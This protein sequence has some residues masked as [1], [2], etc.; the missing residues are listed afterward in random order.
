V[1]ERRWAGQL[2]T[3]NCTPSG[4]AAPFSLNAVH[5]PRVASQAIPTRERF[6]TPPVEAS[7]GVMKNTADAFAACG[8]ESTLAPPLAAEPLTVWIDAV[9]CRGTTMLYPVIGTALVV[10]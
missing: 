2:L 9:A 8:C 6:R 4:I 7:H 5:A 1:D 3:A 10:N